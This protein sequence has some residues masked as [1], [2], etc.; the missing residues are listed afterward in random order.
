MFF[1]IWKCSVFE[2]DIFSQTCILMACYIRESILILFWELFVVSLWVWWCSSFVC[3]RQGTKLKEVEFG[4]CRCWTW[5]N[6]SCEGY[7]FC[8]LLFSFLVLLNITKFFSGNKLVSA[9]WIVYGQCQLVW[10]W[11]HYD[12]CY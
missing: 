10:V 4:S 7:F 11:Y 5:Q 9:D 2:L 8:L 12:W 1:Y 3:Y 6:R